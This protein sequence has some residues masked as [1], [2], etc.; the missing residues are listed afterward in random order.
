MT[1]KTQI[2]EIFT[3]EQNLK[4]KANLLLDDSFLIRDIRIV[5]GKSG[6]FISFPARRVDEKFVDVCFPLNAGLREEIKTLILDEYRRAVEKSQ[7]K[8]DL[9]AEAETGMDETVSEQEA[10]GGGDEA[11]S[12][13]ESDTADGAA[14][15]EEPDADIKTPAKRRTKIKTDAPDRSCDTDE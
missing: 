15:L 8:T 4:A 10:P 11:V 13:S 3:G 2:K 1:I 9:P 6:L 14:P 12:S 7:P 5:E